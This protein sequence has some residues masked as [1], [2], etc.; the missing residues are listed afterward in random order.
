VSIHRVDC[1][2]I[3]N[4]PEEDRER[5]IEAD[6]SEKALTADNTGK[7]IAGITIYAN[8]RTGLLVDITKT[9]TE[10]NIAILSL[11]TATSKKDVATV[12]VSFEI[13]GKEELINIVERLGQIEG[14]INIERTSS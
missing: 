14:I 13:T 11:S 6:W 8:N 5:L 12:Q 3:R 10:K 1:V 4:L 2:N 7:Y 9:L